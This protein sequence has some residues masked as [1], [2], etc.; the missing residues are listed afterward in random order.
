VHCLGYLEAQRYKNEKDSR[1]NVAN[2]STRSLPIERPKEEQKN[3]RSLID[4]T[5]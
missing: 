5:A 1:N 4:S 3:A 2:T